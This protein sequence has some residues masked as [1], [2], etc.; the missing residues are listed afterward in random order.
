[1]A[2]KQKNNPFKSWSSL[3]DAARSK[4]STSSIVAETITGGLN[5]FIDALGSEEQEAWKNKRA[6]KREERAAKKAGK[7][8][9]KEMREKGLTDEEGRLTQ[10]GKEGMSTEKRKQKADDVSDSLKQQTGPGSG[11]TEINLDPNTSFF[12]K[13]RRM[14]GKKRRR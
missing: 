6:E 13:R 1:M 3:A 5:N 11:D 7:K 14:H 9:D 8:V 10:K 12:K 2:Y 4:G